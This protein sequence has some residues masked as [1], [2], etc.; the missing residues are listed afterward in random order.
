MWSSKIEQDFFNCVGIDEVGYGAWAGPLYICAL[1]FLHVTEVKFFDSKLISEKRRVALACEIEKA[2]VWNFGVGSV[3]EI[4]ELGLGQA[5]KKTL[6]RA[7]SPYVC[8]GE[9]LLIDGSR[10]Y[11]NCTAIVKGDQKIQAISAASIMA[12]VCRDNFMLLLHEEF[13]MYKWDKNKGYGTAE[14]ISAIKTHG[15]C[16]WHRSSYKLGKYL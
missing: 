6:V 15:L 5:Y 7:I 10:K 9:R 1:K 16:K 11:P 4:N 2:A 13:P 8:A 12:K 3:E 14:H